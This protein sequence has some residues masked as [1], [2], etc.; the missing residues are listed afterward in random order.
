MVKME[1]GLPETNTAEEAGSAHQPNL[2]QDKH[3]CGTDACRIRPW[4]LEKEEMMG[5][6]LKTVPAPQAILRAWMP[7]KQLIGVTAVRHVSAGVEKRCFL[8]LSE[9]FESLSVRDFY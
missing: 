6:A 5:Y 4:R 2:D 8:G 7:F 9:R 3:E 1:N